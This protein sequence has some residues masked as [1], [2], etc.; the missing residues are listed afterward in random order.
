MKLSTRARYGIHAMYDLAQNYGAQPR[1]LKSRGR[2]AGHSGGVSGTAFVHA[3]A[4]WPGFKRPRR[5][6]RVH[7]FAPAGGNYRGRRSCARWKAG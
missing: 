5:A 6:G 1:P 7:A 3:A 4:R 2:S